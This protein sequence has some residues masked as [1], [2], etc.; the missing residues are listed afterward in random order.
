RQTIEPTTEVLFPVVHDAAGNIQLLPDRT[1]PTIAKRFTYDYRNRL[2]AVES[3]TNYDSDSP[4]WILD[5]T[6][7]YDGLNR[8]VK[9]EALIPK[10]RMSDR[11]MSRAH[12]R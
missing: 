12:H 11:P 2:I 5:V 10:K 6:F 9:K 8:R 1:D 4:S 3:S 7:L